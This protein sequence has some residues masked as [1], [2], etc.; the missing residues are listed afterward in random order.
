VQF[1]QWS[2]SKG[3]DTFTPIGPVI[4]TNV[5]PSGWR[6]QAKVDGVVKQDYVSAHTT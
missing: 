4:V 1:R 3:Y 5:D 6:V 2:R